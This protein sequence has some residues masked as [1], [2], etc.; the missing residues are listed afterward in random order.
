MGTADRQ[1]VALTA[2]RELVGGSSRDQVL[3]HI[4]KAGVPKDDATSVYD[5]ARKILQVAADYRRDMELGTA[6]E[7]L[8]SIIRNCSEITHTE[9]G[10]TM[11]DPRTCLRAQQELSKLMRLYDMD[12]SGV[13]DDQDPGSTD[14]ATELELTRAHLL[15]VLEDPGED[16]PT[17]ELARMASDRIRTNTDG[18]HPAP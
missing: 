1:R 10:E 15:S 3:T 18:A 5:E 17:H 6:I 16:Y 2:A 11:R 8:R 14:H 12:P 4:T 7:R 9:T 13:S